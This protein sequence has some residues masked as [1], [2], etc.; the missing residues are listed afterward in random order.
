MMDHRQ[1][2]PQREVPAVKRW[3]DEEGCILTV[4]AAL[5]A[6]LLLITAFGFM[7]GG[8]RRSGEEGFGCYHYCCPPSSASCLDNRD[9]LY[10]A[11]AEEKGHLLHQPTKDQHVWTAEPH[12]L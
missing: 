5:L 12:L 3:R 8:D 10:P 9:H 7:S 11:E 1:K 4:Q 2:T 6:T